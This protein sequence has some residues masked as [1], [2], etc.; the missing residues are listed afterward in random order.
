LAEYPWTNNTIRQRFQV[1][2]ADT[3]K[4]KF[5]PTWILD[6]F[7]RQVTFIVFYYYQ[8]LMATSPMAEIVPSDAC[9]TAIRLFNWCQDCEFQVV[10][11]Q[12]E[13]EFPKLRSP[14]SINFELILLQV[15]HKQRRRQ[16]AW[17][18]NLNRSKLHV[19]LDQ[20]V[21][22]LNGCYLPDPRFQRTFQMN[23]NSFELSSCAV[24][25]ASGQSS[26]IRYLS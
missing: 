23:R 4:F 3:F 7:P 15:Q 24:Q 17:V 12:L 20:G 8:R 6:Y 19:G 1:S 21:Q 16:N 2:L 25:V 18:L 11:Q 22:V 5:S 26:Y 9:N 14:S 10:M 13:L